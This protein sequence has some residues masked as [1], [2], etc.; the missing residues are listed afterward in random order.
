MKSKLHLALLV[1]ILFGLLSACSTPTAAP[2]QELSTTEPTA[3]SAEAAATIEPTVAEPTAAPA[4]EERWTLYAPASTSSIPVILAAQSL[5]NVDLTLYTNQDQVNTLFTRGEVSVMVTGLAVGVTLYKNGVPLQMANSYVSSLS[6]LVTSGQQVTSFADLKG[7]EV[8][9]PFAGSPIEELCT[10]LAAQEGLVWGTDITP[11]YSPFDASIALLKEGKAAAVVLPE[12]NV[13]LVASQPNIYVSFSLAD[14]WTKANPGQTGYPQVGAFVNK[15][16]AAAHPADVQAFN[17]ALAAAIEL[18]ASDP[19]AA[20]DAVKENYKIPPA[21]LQQALSRTGYS[22][23][24]GADLQTQIDTY[25]QTIGKP[26][27]ET[28]AE[29]YYIAQK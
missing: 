26:L 19:A 5:P 6:Y 20:V 21:V 8:Y 16:W 29:F 9:V 11:V 23:I 17:D 15:E 13:S 18:T 24:T 2:T 1:T 4:A 25:Y 10:Y 28:Y 7:K 14:L 12:P 3:I 22:L 27:D